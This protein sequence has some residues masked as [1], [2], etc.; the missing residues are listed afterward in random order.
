MKIFFLFLLCFIVLLSSVALAQSN[1]D[2]VINSVITG[3]VTDEKTN[4]PLE[5]ALVRIKGITNQ[6]LTNS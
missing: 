2:P 6:T 4:T 3:T 5:G 1:T